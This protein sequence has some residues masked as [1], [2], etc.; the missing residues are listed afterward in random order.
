MKNLFLLFCYSLFS[1]HTIV[2]QEKNKTITF[3]LVIDDEVCKY[4]FLV[5]SE[6]SHDKILATYYPGTLSL[7]KEDYE[8]LISDNTKSIYLKYY[9]NNYINGKKKIL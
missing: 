8:K 7:N 5:N 9:Q 3:V 6:N 1:F 2:A 4:Y